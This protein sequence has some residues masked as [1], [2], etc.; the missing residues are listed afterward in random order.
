MGLIPYR[1]WADGATGATFL[2]MKHNKLFGVL[3]LGGAVLGLGCREENVVAQD[4]G[5]PMSD[6]AQAADDAAS[7]DDA[8]PAVGD[9]GATQD[10]PLMNGGFCPNDIGCEVGPDGQPRERAGLMCCWGT[11]C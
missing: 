11:H 2:V 6:A 5:L 9:A 1:D 7:A 10:A 8:A 3:V 4:G